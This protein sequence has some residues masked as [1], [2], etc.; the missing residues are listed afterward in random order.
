MGVRNVINVML[1]YIYYISDTHCHGH[2]RANATSGRGAQPG[3]DY[4]HCPFHQRSRRLASSS[5][6][7][8]LPNAMN[9]RST[10][11]ATEPRI[12]A[13]DSAWMPGGIARGLG[14]G[15]GIG[16]AVELILQ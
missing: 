2:S 11:F 12:L 8:C 14:A 1:L 15:M 10:L 13:H 9:E 4:S 7:R 16:G 5:P 6:H 3:V